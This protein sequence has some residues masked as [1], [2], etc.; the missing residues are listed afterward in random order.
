MYN[1]KYPFSHYYTKEEK[2]DLW[3]LV[4]ICLL[5]V[6]LQLSLNFVQA[7]V[8][9][10]LGNYFTLTYSIVVFIVFGG[11]HILQGI[12]NSRRSSRDIRRGI[13]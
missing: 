13:K 5:I 1:N 11:G 2:R 12:I 7:F 4:L 9:W 3:G 10:S 8:V 6:V